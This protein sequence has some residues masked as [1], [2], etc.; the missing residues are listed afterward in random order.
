GFWQIRG[1]WGEGREWVA[2]AV[3]EE[4]VV[5][6]NT[7]RGKAV[8]GAGKLAYL[9]DDYAAALTLYQESLAIY[10]QNGDK[11][12]VARSL[13]GLGHTTRREGKHAEA[14]SLLE[15]SLSIFRDLGDRQ[16]IA[17]A[18]RGIGHVATVQSDPAARSLYEESLALF[19]A[20]A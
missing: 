14:R 20:M 17:N 2:M 19:R 7:E 1:H 9:Q 15:E 13:E 6:A 12:G 11:Q 18:L 10:K 4:A 8:E 3:S 5:E 16:G